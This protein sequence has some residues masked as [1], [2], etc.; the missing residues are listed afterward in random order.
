MAAADW[1]RPRAVT[2]P[3][4]GEEELRRD[5]RAMLDAALAAVEPAALV[6]EE[7]RARPLEPGNG[8]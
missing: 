8:G 1:A 4:V 3:R 2:G 7:L 5:A 6:V